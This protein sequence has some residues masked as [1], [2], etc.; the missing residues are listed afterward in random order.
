MVLSALTS[1]SDNIID[2]LT[3]KDSP[4]SE[5]ADE[6]TDVQERFKGLCETVMARLDAWTEEAS[7]FESFLTHLTD[8]SNWLNEFYDTLYDEVCVRIQPKA[9]DEIIARHRNKLEVRNSCSIVCVRNFTK[10][11]RNNNYIDC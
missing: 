8:F 9:S 6:S 7:Q 5:I 3:K 10:S 1:T 4:S 11:V 2:E